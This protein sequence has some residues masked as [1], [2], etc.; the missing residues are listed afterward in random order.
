MRKSFRW[1]AALPPTIL[2]TSLIILP[3]LSAGSVD[4]ASPAKHR[5]KSK[6]IHAQPATQGT[7]LFATGGL[8]PTTSSIK[9]VSADNHFTWMRVQPTTLVV[10]AGR[11]ME[12]GAITEGDKLLCQGAWVDDS[13]GPVFQAKRVEIIGR[14]SEVGLQEKVAAACQS[15]A[16]SGSRRSG[17]AGESSFGKVNT[18]NL[19]N[20]Q[21]QELQDYQTSLQERSDAVDRGKAKLMDQIEKASTLGYD[22]QF[23][24]SFTQARGDYES[25][26]DKL[27]SIRPIP[28]AMSK[29]NAL[30]QQGVS[31]YRQESSLWARFYRTIALGQD[32]QILVK[33]RIKL[34]D[35]GTRFID[36]AISESKKVV[37]TSP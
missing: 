29:A 21:A 19:V 7:R 27:A 35:E 26:L 10:Q 20:R 32:D 23:E 5:P 11:H 28:P 22:R 33:K 13:W 3:M 25:A 9:A 4:A 2:S 30:A 14:I 31:S 24:A 12:P 8:D 18:D 6:S 37:G 34:F 16:D 17:G 1:L 36:A 15:V